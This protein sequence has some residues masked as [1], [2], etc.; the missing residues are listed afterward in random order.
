SDYSKGAGTGI[1]GAAEAEGF[2]FAM[3]PKEESEAKAQPEAEAE[4]KRA[5]PEPEPEPE[6]RRELVPQAQRSLGQRIVSEPVGAWVPERVKEL[7]EKH[8]VIG[9][10][11]GKCVVME[12][13]P[14]VITP[15][16]TELS[17]QTFTSFRERYANLY[18]EGT[19]SRG[20]REN[21]PAAPI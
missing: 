3:Q 6:K 11:G 13:I 19:D 10:L 5:E 18:I 17:Y 15:G 20:R 21:M 1:L 9:N 7:N 16:G 14:S 2:Y 12:W 8:A 4:P